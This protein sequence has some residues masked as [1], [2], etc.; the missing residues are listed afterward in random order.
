MDAV[1]IAKFKKSGLGDSLS[2]TNLVID[3]PVHLLRGSE[4][5][6]SPESSSESESRRSTTSALSA[7]QRLA[8]PSPHNESMYPCRSSTSFG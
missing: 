3:V 4:S 8:K 6:Q 5:T 2:N 7:L 1:I